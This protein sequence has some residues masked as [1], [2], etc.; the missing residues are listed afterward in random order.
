[1]FLVAG[2]VL[3]LVSGGNDVQKALS[4][5]ALHGFLSNAKDGSSAPDYRFV[6]NQKVIDKKAQKKDI[7]VPEV[8]QLATENRCKFIMTKLD[9]GILVNKFDVAYLMIC[10]D[11]YPELFGNFYDELHPKVPK[12]TPVRKSVPR[13]DKTVETKPLPVTETTPADQGGGS[14]F[15]TEL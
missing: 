11:K 15:D 9:A 14:L 2:G 10:F 1:M 7:V 4:A 6:D 13:V 3:M 12:D 8:L 5:F